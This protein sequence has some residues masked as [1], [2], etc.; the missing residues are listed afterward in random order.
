MAKVKTAGMQTSKAP[1]GKPFKG[2]G[3]KDQFT[4]R[5]GGPANRTGKKPSYGK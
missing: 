2:A 4:G 3:A 1:F 5:I